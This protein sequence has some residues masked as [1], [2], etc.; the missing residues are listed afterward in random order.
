MCKFYGGSQKKILPFFGRCTIL[1]VEKGQ[2][3]ERG[4][5]SGIFPG[6]AIVRGRAGLPGIVQGMLWIFMIKW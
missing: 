5:V 6:N 4:C 1:M 2:P 3:P